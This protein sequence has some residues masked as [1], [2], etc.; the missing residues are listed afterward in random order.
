M[1]QQINGEPSN[2]DLLRAALL[3]PPQLLL[4]LRL[5]YNG[6]PP[7]TPAQEKLKTLWDKDPDKFL[8]R[9]SQAEKDYRTEQGRKA[10]GVV[11]DGPEA[12]IEDKQSDKIEALIQRILDEANREARGE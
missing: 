2:E 3:E 9:L 10:P 1:N 5:V 4:D 8:T 6:V 12:P 11:Q 7:R